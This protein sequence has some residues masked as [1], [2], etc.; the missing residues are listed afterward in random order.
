MDQLAQ[1]GLAKLGND[2]PDVRVVGEDLHALEEL[3]DEPVADLRHLFFGVPLQYAR[4]VAEGGLSE[5][6]SGDDR[7][8]YAR[9]SL[10]LASETETPC[11]PPSRPIPRPPRA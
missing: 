8:S 6:Y 5:A 1:E 10:A 9:P 3:G 2:P 7:T 11:L 4:Q